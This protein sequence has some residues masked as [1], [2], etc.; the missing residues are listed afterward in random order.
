M[1]ERTYTIQELRNLISESASEFKAKVGD[2]VNNA[3][4]KENDSTYA[5]IKKETNALDGEKK[6]VSKTITDKEDGNKTTLDYAL[7]NNCGEDFAEKVKAQSEG[8]TSTLEKKNGIEKVGDFNDKTY[9]QFKKAG[10]EMAKNKVE[11]KKSGL[12]ARELPDSVFKKPDMYGES[13][14]IA[15]LNFKNTVFLNESHMISRIPDDYKVEGKCFKVKDSNE[16]EFIVEWREGEANILFHENKKKLNESIEKYHK[17]SGYNS[18]TQTTKSSVAN[19]L[20]ESTEFSKIL[21]KMRTI[22]KKE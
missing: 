3:N 14:K 13:K 10:K 17:L 2:N 7:E 4:K 1:S 22:S 5:K 16:N 15:V 20:N 8:Y 19:R 9:K 12:T 21:E 6:D 18:K 11:A